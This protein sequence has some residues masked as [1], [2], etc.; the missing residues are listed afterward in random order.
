MLNKIAKRYDRFSYF[1][2][3]LE[4]FLENRL[5]KKWRQEILSPLRGKILEI[6]VGTGKNLP[7]YSPGAEITAIDFSP[8]MLERAQKKLEKIATT[9]IKLKEMTAENLA[10]PD[11]SFD[12]VVTTF[13]WCSV[14]Q[15]IKGLKEAK[16]VLKPEGEGI[17]LEHVLSKNKIIAF[18]QHL[19]NPLTR[20]LFGFN[21][22]RDTR[23]YLEETGFQII[24]DKKMTLG[25][26]FR[27]FR[28]KKTKNP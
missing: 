6:G 12:Y 11:N 26:I 25:D 22:N 10:F 3:F 8:K 27:L 19:H 15:V 2:D 17:F 20:F 28:V 4:S 21:V 7:F 5:F 24:Q 16:R 1:Y 14:P 9:N 18:W 13:V 23:S